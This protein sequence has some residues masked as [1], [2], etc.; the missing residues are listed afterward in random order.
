MDHILLKMLF[1]RAIGD[2]P[3]P[4]PDNGYE[5]TTMEEMNRRND[6]DLGL[7]ANYIMLFL[8]CTDEILQK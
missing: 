8:F 6:Q 7:P 3:C 5:V 2:E 1:T 4:V